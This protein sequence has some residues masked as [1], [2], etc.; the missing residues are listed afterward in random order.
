MTAFEI[1]SIL[2]GILTLLFT[3]GSFILTCLSLIIH[4]CDK[5][6]KTKNNAHSKIRCIFRQ[7]V[8]PFS[9]RNP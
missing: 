2:I 8:L 3:F 5:D 6:K 4:I 7:I 1:I 9:L